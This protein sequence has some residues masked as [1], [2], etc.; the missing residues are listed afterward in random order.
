[1][2][3]A[4]LR[5]EKDRQD[6]DE[7]IA[8]GL[9]DYTPDEHLKAAIQVDKRDEDASLTITVDHIHVGEDGH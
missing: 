5:R 9:L 3:R 2:L 6:V 8:C 4:I 1:M 7:H